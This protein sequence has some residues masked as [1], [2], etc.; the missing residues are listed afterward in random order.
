MSLTRV[1][2]ATPW[3]GARGLTPQPRPVMEATWYFHGRTPLNKQNI[4]SPQGGSMQFKYP[5]VFWQAADPFAGNNFVAGNKDYLFIR[6]TNLS[7]PRTAT[8]Y[9]YPEPVY[10][11]VGDVVITV[12]PGTTVIAYPIPKQGFM[13]LDGTIWLLGQTAEILF[14]PLTFS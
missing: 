12:D 3:L 9:S 14:L 13:Q 7:L 8:I 11:R 4:P 5:D 10:G 2:Q 6:N 1:V